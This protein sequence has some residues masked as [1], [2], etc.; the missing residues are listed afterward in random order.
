[1]KTRHVAIFV[2]LSLMVSLPLQA[3]RRNHDRQFDYSLMGGLN[4]SQ[5]DGDN[6][7]KYNKMGLHGA[8]NTS[9][10]ISQDKSWRFLVEIGFTQKGSYSSNID[11]T[12]ALSYVEVPLMINYNAA[13]DRLR[14]GFGVAPAILAKSRVDDS[15]VEIA[16]QSANYR[17]F[18]AIPI[19]VDLRYKVV[20]GLAVEARYYNSMLSCAKE[21]G[22]GTYRIFRSNKGQFNRLIT[23]GLAYCL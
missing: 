18:D 2:L 11:R 8:V 9:F 13:N 6:S 5:I 1:M 21:S 20:G 19:C 3:Q 4:M 14:I 12:I 23:V 17:R 15:G 22:S 7:G 16:S 10:P